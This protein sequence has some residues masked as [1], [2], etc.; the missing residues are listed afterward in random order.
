[1]LQAISGKPLIASLAA[2]L[3][4]YPRGGSTDG[5]GVEGSF[6]RAVVVCHPVTR[7]LEIVRMRPR[8]GVECKN[9]VERRWRDGVKVLRGVGGLYIE[10]DIVQ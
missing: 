4:L 1:V 6:W 7:S 9:I 5:A 10:V 8:P 3:G 2:Y